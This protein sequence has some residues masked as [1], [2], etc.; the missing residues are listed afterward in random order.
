MVRRQSKKGKSK[1]WGREGE[2]SQRN[3]LS[4]L[5]WR[6]REGPPKLGNQCE[7]K[8]Q[9]FQHTNSKFCI[10][11]KWSPIFSKL[12][13]LMDFF[14]FYKGV[15]TFVSVLVLVEIK[16]RS[17]IITMQQKRKHDVETET[18]RKDKRELTGHPGNS[19]WAGFRAQPDWDLEFKPILD[20]KEQGKNL[21]CLLHSCTFPSISF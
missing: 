20:P 16:G 9:E 5:S 12:I 4:A 3:S 2:R 17:A 10:H 8:G 15:F 21:H 6:V 19:S 11:W 13:P 7:F 1:L 14:F 18:H